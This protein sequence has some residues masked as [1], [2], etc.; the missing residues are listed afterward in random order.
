MKTQPLLVAAVGAVV[1]LIVGIVA[2]GGGLG[3]ARLV[4]CGAGLGAAAATDLA[5]HRIPNRLVLPAAA[6]CALL[7]LAAGVPLHG[8]IV[9]LPLV[10]LLLSLSLIRPQALGMGD[11]K[12]ALLIVL[13]LNGSAADALLL[14]LALAATYAL[15]LILRYGR[16]AMQTALPLAP[17]L[18]SG[19]LLALLA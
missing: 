2:D 3:I 7:S 1:F 17:F 12:L 4:I 5:E 6:A 8:L 19:A 11:V 18:C 13:G 15:L 14:G 9:G 10:A 16:P